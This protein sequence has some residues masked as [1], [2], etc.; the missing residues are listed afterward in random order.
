MHRGDLSH[1]YSFPTTSARVREWEN[2]APCVTRPIY[3]DEELWLRFRG[4]LGDKRAILEICF[5]TSES[6][7]R[8]FLLNKANSTGRRTNI[9]VTQL[10]RQNRTLDV[11][12]IRPY[13]PRTPNLPFRGGGGPLSLFHLLHFVQQLQ[14]PRL[15]VCRT[16]VCLD[17]YGCL[18]L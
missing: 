3:H 16:T 7:Y 8:Q 10:W 14:T 12:A 13:E 18:W 15:P 9:D 6:A 4:R 5:H 1:I 17:Q 2:W 11:S